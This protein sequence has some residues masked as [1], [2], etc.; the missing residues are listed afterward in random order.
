MIPTLRRAFASAIILLVSLGFALPASAWPLRHLTHQRLGSPPIEVLDCN[1]NLRNTCYLR[2]NSCFYHHSHAS[3]ASNIEL[4]ACQA[5]YFDCIYR[6]RCQR[7]PV[8]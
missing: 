7:G 1:V 2:M 4:R 6:F 3:P 8:W 5:A